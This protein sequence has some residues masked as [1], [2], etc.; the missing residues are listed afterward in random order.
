MRRGTWILA[1]SGAVALNAC[2]AYS[3]DPKSPPTGGEAPPVPTRYTRQL[4]PATAP[5]RN[6]YEELFGET[7][8]KSADAK[9]AEAPAA[10]PAEAT[11]QKTATIGRGTANRAATAPAARNPVVENSPVT[12][13]VAA[14]GNPSS[15]APVVQAAF[16]KH[17]EE[18]ERLYIQPVAAAVSDAKP[19]KASSTIAPGE[20]ATQLPMLSI[21]WVRRGEINVGQECQIDLV[22]KNFGSLPA[23]QV[24]V[25]ATFPASVRLTSA[26]PKPTS[27]ADKA[28]WNFDS[29]APGA[30]RRMAIKFI[31]SRRGEL[32]LNA[33]VRFTGQAAAVFK[34]EEPQLKLAIKGPSE[35]LLGD[36][37]TQLITITNSGTGVAH[38]VKLEAR[39]SEGLEH[40]DGQRVE[41]TVG[42]L[43]A[44]ESQ[45]VR[46]GL[47]ASKGGPQTIQFLATSSCEATCTA[48][49]KIT[50]LAPSLQATLQG[51][52]LRYK[53]RNARYA[54]TVHNDGTVPNNNV[55]VSQAVPEGFQ[56]V[57][58]ERGGKF[59]PSQKSIHWFIGRLEAGQSVQLDCEL[60]AAALGDFKHAAT[61]YSENG[62]TARAE[63]TTRVEGVASIET[64]IVDLDDPVE[65]G[66][67]TAWEIRVKN[68]G[69]KPAGNVAI[70]CELPAGVALLSAKGATTATT[71]GKGVQFKALPQLPP[72]QQ[73]VYRVHVRGTVEGTHRLRARVTSDALDQPVTLEEP[74][75]FY[76]DAKN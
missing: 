66:S 46:L 10:K 60:T 56:F 1:V 54:L 44:G 76:A 75:R 4:K 26:E 62:V 52:G 34:V 7:A 67:E 29:L 18:N 9:P 40:R 73:A 19:T 30:E 8:A 45:Q 12:T 63:L 69:S 48:S 11:V 53:G 50:V 65:L 70:Q 3:A 35:V 71:Q 51:P 2:G 37:A 55:R 39:L 41:I 36:P 23:A 42:S 74:T 47:A 31:P 20:S 25:D 68:T 38:H 28:S 14:E 58:A 59:D 17:P 22:V 6:Y 57:S 64:E 49:T 21:E 43:G 5:P 72:G 15:G 24:A 13:P 16:E 27:T 61:V 33:A 32:G